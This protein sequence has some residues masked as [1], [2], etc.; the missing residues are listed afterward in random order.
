[1]SLQK[2]CAYSTRPVTG[3]QWVIGKNEFYRQDPTAV[4]LNAVISFPLSEAIVQISML[5]NEVVDS[6]WMVV[7]EVVWEGNVILYPQYISD[8]LRKKAILLMI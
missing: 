3:S 1:M 5:L 6:S 7:L 8:S 4:L 2:A